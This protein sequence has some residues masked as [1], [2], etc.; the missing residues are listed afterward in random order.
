MLPALAR[1]RLGGSV[2]TIAD[3]ADVAIAGLLAEACGRDGP[4]DLAPHARRV[5][6]AV[7][8]Q[9]LFGARLSARVDELSDLFQRPQAY[10]ESPAVKQMPHPFPF[11]R[12][13]RVRRDR[14]EI[15]SIVDAEIA[16]R[17]G[18]P[19][20]DE[21]DLLTDLVRSGELTDAEIRDQVVTLIGAGYDTTAASLLWTV[22]RATTATGVWDELRREADAALRRT[23]RGGLAR[24]TAVRRTGCPRD[25]ATAPGRRRRPAPGGRGHRHRLVRAAPWHAG[26]AVALPRRAQP[27]SVA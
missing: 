14:R 15:D 16:H 18:D 1:R 10:L 13:A 4:I 8:V 17:R 25:V 19:G 23:D 9:V 6:M 22:W 5:T 27:S 3:Q 20:Y 2:T 7:V 26:D 21:R 12:R 24:P 11:T